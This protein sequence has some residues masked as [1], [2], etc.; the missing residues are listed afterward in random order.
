MP[1][2]TCCKLDAERQLEELRQSLYVFEH[3]GTTHPSKSLQ[4]ILLEA[5]AAYERC[6]YDLVTHLVRVGNC[7]IARECPIFKASPQ[8]WIEKLKTLASIVLVHDKE[9]VA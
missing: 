9:S 7:L 8:K 2:K 5:E 6:A 4:Q 1:N 3:K